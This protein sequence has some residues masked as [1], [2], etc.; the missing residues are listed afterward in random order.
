MAEKKG[1]LK[2]SEI[3]FLIDD[4]DYIFSDFDP[5][6]Y[7]N[8]ALSD[9]F[10]TEARKASI[11]KNPGNIQLKFL[12][13]KRNRKQ[14]DEE[15]IKKRLKQHF[16]K[17]EEQ[18]KSEYKKTLSHGILFFIFGIM[19]M[20]AA[21]F[22]LFKYPGQSLPENFILILLEPIGWFLFWE[23]LELVIFKSKDVKPNFDF[24]RKMAN[25]DIYFQSH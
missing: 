21:A 16:Y 1:K 20:F 24:Y 2:D 25:A 15:V 13:P 12:I 8:R 11:D 14:K 22:V 9:D 18:S 4:Y 10:L 23:G 5:R 7:S 3:G 19:L 6:P 17:H